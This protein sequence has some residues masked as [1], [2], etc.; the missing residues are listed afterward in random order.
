MSTATIEKT[1][2]KIRRAFIQKIDIA[3]QQT[4]QE[5]LAEEAAMGR[6]IAPKNIKPAPK[7]EKPEPGLDWWSAYE[8]SRADRF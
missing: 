4:F 3:E 7:P 2:T 6:I 1:Q 5:W 8:Y